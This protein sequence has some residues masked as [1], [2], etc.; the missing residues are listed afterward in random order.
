ML[1]TVLNWL[2]KLNRHK[3]RGLNLF[4]PIELCCAFLCLVASAN[5]VVGS[6]ASFDR[7]ADILAWWPQITREQ[8]PWAYWW[9]MGSAVDPAN[10]TKELTR[11][12]DAGYGGVH[13]I[14]IYGAIGWETNYISYISP[15]WM[16][17]LRHTVSEAKRLD[18]GVD[19]TTGTGWCFGGPRVTDAEANAAVVAKTFEVA[20]GGKL[21][22]KF[23][24]TNTQ[25][26]VAF[27]TNGAS[28]EL[29]KIIRADGSVNWIADGGPWRVYAISQKPSGQKVKRASPGGEG[30][31]LNLIYPEAVRDYL[32]WFDEAFARY[33]GPKPRAQYHDSYEYRSDWSPDFFAQFEKRRGYRLQTELPALFGKDTNDH[34]ARVLCDYRETV[35]DVMVEESLPLWVKWSHARGFLTRNEA[36]GSPGNLLDLYSVA[37]IPETEMF[38]KDRNKLISKFASS[39][40]H[41]SGKKL[42][43]CETG[44]WLQEHFTETLADMK[45]LL[46]DLFLSGVNHVFYHGTCYSPDEAGWPG[47]LFYASYEMNPRNS[48]WRDVP[49]L[50]AYVARCQSVLQSGQPDNDI[51]LYWPIHDFWS[52]P[53]GRLLPHMTVHARDWF[54]AQPVGKLAE[55]LWNRGYSFDYV[56][57]R[58]LA[59]A[60]LKNGKVEMP[61][62]SYRV[63]V[64]PTCERMPVATLKKLFSL[65]ESGATVI[66]ENDLPKDVPGLGALEKRRKEFVQLTT[67]IG[68]PASG[69]ARSDEARETRRAGGRRSFPLG[70]GRM[71][72]G[73]VE[74]TLDAAGVARETLFDQPGLMCLRRAF[75]GG[76]H[77]FIA[78]RGEQTFEGWLSLATA[79]K[80]VVIM[81]ALNRRTGVAASRQSAANSTQ[82]FLQLQPGE[83]V[84]LRVFTKD[85]VNGA[86]WAYAGPTGKPVELSGEWKVKF[87]QGG[88]VLPPE[89]RATKLASWTELGGEEAQRFAGTARYAITFDAPPLESSLQA[90]PDTLKRELQHF[91]LDLDKVCQSARVRLN[92][93]DLGTLITPPFRVVVSNLKPKDNLLE[94]EVTNVSANRIRDLDRRGVKWKNFHDINFVNLNYRP[95]DASAWPLTDSGL[96]GPVTLTAVN[97]MSPAKEVS[98]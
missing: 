56:S 48:V 90:V 68:A 10:L 18:L 70:K 43:G 97:A 35:S 74:V 69:L 58:Q 2:P 32:R 83:A 60:R 8:R 53:G 66:F 92:G 62:S 13:I 20:P 37:D 31:M 73:E 25:A 52:Q 45:Y 67:R 12:R 15:Q 22:E 94:V 29:T 77:Y 34:T 23:D 11:Y 26:L 88:P 79:A 75:D 61:E 4:R 98:R 39:A 28:I 55:Q 16:D 21:A 84:I 50:N 80:S 27:S 30:H 87:V 81:D 36:H 64:V 3:K 76:R 65:A 47:W 63:V 17:M 51:L 86:A 9:W 85:Q 14:P 33:D 40:A 59:A 57:D 82:V 91:T 7:D 19:M 44:T 96:L 89:F 78:N 5:A 93:Q 42:V 24:R 49:A 6:A 71:L 1:Q 72:L 46:D 95:F 38:Y 41:V 54:E